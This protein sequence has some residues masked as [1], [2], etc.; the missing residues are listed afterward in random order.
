M[1]EFVKYTLLLFVVPMVCMCFVVSYHP[2]EKNSLEELL[3]IPIGTIGVATF[4]AGAVI[5]YK[6]ELKEDA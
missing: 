4:I 2:N 5:I 1:R 6:Q 3:P